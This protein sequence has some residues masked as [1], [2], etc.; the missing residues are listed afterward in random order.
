MMFF[1]LVQQQN[2]QRK[3]PHFARGTR[4]AYG[5]QRGCSHPLV[6]AANNAEIKLASAARPKRQKGN[7]SCNAYLPCGAG[8]EFLLTITSRVNVSQTSHVGPKHSIAQEVHHAL[9]AVTRSAN[10]LSGELHPTLL[11]DLRSVKRVELI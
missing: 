10:R 6:K 2:L 4:T 3:R 7:R 5:E 1:L 9:G 8:G 11:F